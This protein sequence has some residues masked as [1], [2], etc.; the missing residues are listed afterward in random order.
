LKALDDDLIMRIC[1]HCGLEKPVS[2]FHYASRGNGL[3]SWCK[4]CVTDSKRVKIAAGIEAMRQYLKAHGC[5]DCHTHDVRVLDF[6]HIAG[7]SRDGNAVTNFAH[8][9]GWSHPK[10]QVEVAHC[11]VR[12]ANCHRIRHWESKL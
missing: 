5:K 2:E 11:E 6:D 4:T 7:S 12:C 3:Q 8:S 9:Y 10:T 1:P